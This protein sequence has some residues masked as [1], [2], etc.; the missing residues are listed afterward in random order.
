MSKRTADIIRRLVIV[1]DIK[2]SSAKKREKSGQNFPRTP[3]PSRMHF[4]SGFW[5]ITE[6]MIFLFY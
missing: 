5:K 3:F 4:G 2:L 1:S 6:E